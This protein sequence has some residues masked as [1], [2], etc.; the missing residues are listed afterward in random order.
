MRAALSMI[1]VSFYW[2]CDGLFYGRDR[3]INNVSKVNVYG[4]CECIS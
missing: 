4:K 2:D 3:E 1:D